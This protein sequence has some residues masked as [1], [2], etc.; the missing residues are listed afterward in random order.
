MKTHLIR[1]C[2]LAAGLLALA[3]AASLAQTLTIYTISSPPSPPGGGTTG[4]GTYQIG[5][6]VSLVAS[7]NPCWLFDHWVDNGGNINDSNPYNITVSSEITNYTAVFL[8]QS[9]QIT[10]GWSPS[11]G[12]TSTGGGSY[13]CGTNV[14]LLAISNNPCYMF[15]N[16]NDGS[17]DNPHTVTAS[18]DA[19]YTAN[20]VPKQFTIKTGFAPPEVSSPN[21]DITTGDTTTNCGAIVVLTANPTPCLLFTNWNDGSTDNPHTVTASGDAAY[22]ANY[23]PRQCAIT[24]KVA[25]PGSGTTTGDTVTN[26]GAI[27]TVTAQPN[28]GYKFLYWTER[29]W[30]FGSSPP[31]FTINCLSTSAKYTFVASGFKELTANFVDTNIN[32]KHPCTCPIFPDGKHITE[33][34]GG[35]TVRVYA[36]FNCDWTYDH[37]PGHIHILG[38]THTN[39]TYAVDA[40]PP[41]FQAGGPQY[42][43]PTVHVPFSFQIAG[44]TYTVLQDQATGEHSPNS[45]P[46]PPNP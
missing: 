36:G 5:T 22:T 10:V 8:P 40:L 14:V 42:Q 12:G 17:T 21:G 9:C 28:A 3:P 33:A 27:V 31:L 30:I 13:L 44:Q 23:V 7:N 6:H 29:L 32:P 11:D 26:C 18:G 20:F 2:L 37:V 25:P 45:P 35:G 4:G 15:T 38:H 19:T 39:L 34:G 43:N 24:T 16:W 46:T 41:A 1:F